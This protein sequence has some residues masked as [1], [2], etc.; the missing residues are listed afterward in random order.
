MA[1]QPT[2]EFSTRFYILRPEVVESYF[3]LWKLTGNEMYRDWAWDVVLVSGLQERKCKIFCDCCLQ[4]RVFCQALNKICRTQNGFTGIRD[5]NSARPNPDNVQQ[6]F[7]MAETLKYLY[8]T[9]LDDEIL[10]LNAWVFNTEAHPLPVIG[11]FL[12]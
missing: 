1:G 4:F 12:P 9:F 5:V 6:S 10:P 7:F 2:P 3:Y 8:L 11:L